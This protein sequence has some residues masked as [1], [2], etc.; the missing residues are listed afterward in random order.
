LLTR[1]IVCCL[2]SSH[3]GHHPCRWLGYAALSGD[4]RH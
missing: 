2:R 4:A 3:E 1:L